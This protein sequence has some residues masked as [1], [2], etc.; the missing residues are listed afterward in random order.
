MGVFFILVPAT[1]SQIFVEEVYFYKIYNFRGRGNRL[2]NIFYS[3]KIRNL[4]LI[5]FNVKLHSYT[6]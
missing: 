3:K 4:F 6:L 2:K 1:N 5:K